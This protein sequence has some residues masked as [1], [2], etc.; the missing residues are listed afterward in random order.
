MAANGSAF[1][2]RECVELLADYMD[3]TLSAQQKEQLEDHLSHCSPC[4]TFVRT[5]KATARLCRT[6]LAAAMPQEL[7]NR[8]HNFLAHGLPP[9]KV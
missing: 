4:V 9:R 3:G 6:H 1:Y 5:Y 7:S 8:L 2:C